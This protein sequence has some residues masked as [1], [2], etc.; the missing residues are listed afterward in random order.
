MSAFLDPDGSLARPTQ[1]L[2]SPPLRRPLVNRH[3]TCA[4]SSPQP[5]SPNSETGPALLQNHIFPFC[6]ISR[7]LS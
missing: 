2:P 5:L 6:S 7:L 3:I 4:P 1:R